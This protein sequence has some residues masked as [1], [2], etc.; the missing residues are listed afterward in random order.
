MAL[1]APIIITAEPECQPIKFDAE[2]MKEP[3]DNTRT[4]ILLEPHA[5]GTYTTDQ[6]R[7]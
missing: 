2:D 7:L 3:A 5:G 4:A 1:L 6:D